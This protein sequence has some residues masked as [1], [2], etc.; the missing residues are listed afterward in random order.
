M[1]KA[2][3]LEFVVDG[4]LVMH[5]ERSH[6]VW[7]R[8]LLESPVHHSQAG[9]VIPRVR[10]S[11]L[12]RQLHQLISTSFTPNAAMLY[13]PISCVSVVATRMQHVAV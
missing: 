11:S 8:M 7:R 2:C 5:E 12:G 1:L 13:H 4:Q 10:D 9:H 6:G 3:I